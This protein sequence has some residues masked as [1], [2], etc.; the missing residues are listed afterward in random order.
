MGLP[1]AVFALPI[2]NWAYHI[3]QAFDPTS[4]CEN[5]TSGNLGGCSTRVRESSRNRQMVE[6]NIEVPDWSH[7]VCVTMSPVPETILAPAL[8]CMY[9]YNKRKHC[10]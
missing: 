4:R 6:S 1:L 9:R 2:R 10:Q 5:I 8:M 3:V 7:K